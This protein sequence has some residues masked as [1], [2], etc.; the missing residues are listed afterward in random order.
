MLWALCFTLFLIWLIVNVNKP[1][2]NSFSNIRMPNYWENSKYLVSSGNT[3]FCIVFLSSRQVLTCRQSQP[4]ASGPLPFD[5][6]IIISFHHFP[7]L[8]W[9]F[10][11]P[12]SP[13]TF[14]IIQPDWIRGFSFPPASVPWSFS[15]VCLCVCVCV[16]MRLCAV[17][18]CGCS[19]F[20]LGGICR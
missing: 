9:T 19:P 8:R 6:T 14:H 13:L 12:G 3:I 11:S 7:D 5:S 10:C 2:F 4:I 18:W 17:C 20:P 1:K 16:H 15:N